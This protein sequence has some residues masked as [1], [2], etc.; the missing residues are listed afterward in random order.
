MS[1][2]LYK[3]KRFVLFGDKILPTCLCGDSSVRDERGKIPFSGC[4]FNITDDAD[5]LLFDREAWEAARAARLEEERKLQAEWNNYYLTRPERDFMK[6]ANMYGNSYD[7]HHDIRS[8]MSFLSW[9]RPVTIEDFIRTKNP[10]G[11][12]IEAYLVDPKTYQRVGDRKH[13]RVTNVETAEAADR[14]FYS[15]VHEW[16]E[17]G[18]PACVSVSF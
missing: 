2:Y 17:A 15:L 5:H 14:E 7:G 1:Y 4:F 8:M 18:K 12:R 11:V 6:M 13:W 10:D 9:G 16:H 3:G